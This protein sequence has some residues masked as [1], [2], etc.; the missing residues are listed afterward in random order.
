MKIQT[1]IE[2]EIQPSIFPHNELFYHCGPNFDQFSTDF[3]GRGENNHILGHGIYFIN[4][5]HTALGYAKYLAGGVV[6]VLY[7]VKINGNNDTLYCSR[8][9]PSDKQQVSLDNIA[10]ALGYETSQDVPYRHSTMQYGRGLPGAVFAKLGTKAGLKLLIENGIHGQFEDVGNGLFEVAVYDTRIVQ[11][12][13][14]VEKPELAKEAPAP[15][16]ELDKWFDDLMNGK[17]S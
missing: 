5:E 16:P 7:Q 12:M 4:S 6:P 10:K 8:N 14:K 9:R 13:N 17:L 11:I 2:T 15:D 1:I 3:L